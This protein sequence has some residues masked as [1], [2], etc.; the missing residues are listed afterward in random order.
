MPIT[1]DDVLRV[2]PG[3]R[4]VSQPEH[5][6]HS[7]T[8]L[9]LTIKKG[10]SMVITL[11]RVAQKP[12]QDFQGRQ[13]WGVLTQQYGAQQWV[14]LQCDHQPMVGQSYDVQIK[15]KPKNNGGF[16]MDATII[17][18]AHQPPAAQPQFSPTPQ[19][20]ARESAPA[21]QLG[22]LAPQ[23]APQQVVH[24]APPSAPTVQAPPPSGKIAWEDW[25]FV[26]GLAWDYAINR[27]AMPPA[28]AVAYVSTTLIAFSKGNLELPAPP[29]REPGSDDDITF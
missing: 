22:P 16:F 21:D 18:P 28:E 13:V 7:L 19:R 24:Q 5:V 20:G 4:I 6:G 8:E 17:G 1:A 14:D 29:A 3:A 9:F 26:T 27:C 2:F 11:T 12:K 15:Q 10:G 25:V 23:Q